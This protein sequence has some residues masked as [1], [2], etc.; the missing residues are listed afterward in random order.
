[1]CGGVCVCVGGG[2]LRI[3]CDGRDVDFMTMMCFNQEARYRGSFG[4]SKSKKTRY[5]ALKI[6][7]TN[8]EK[9]DKSH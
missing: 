6:F 3:E 2:Y 9:N 5:R 8:R 1:M 7:G 4:F